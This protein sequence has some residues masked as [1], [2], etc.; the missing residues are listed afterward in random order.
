MN[1]I[2]GLPPTERICNYTQTINIKPLKIDNLGR[3]VF[4][5]TQFNDN[6]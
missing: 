5:R 3:M 1:N 6:V 4:R 2:L